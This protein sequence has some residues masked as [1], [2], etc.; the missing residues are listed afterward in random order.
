MSTRVDPLGV[1]S[2]QPERLNY[3][4]GILLDAQDFR[5]EQLYHR[6]RLARALAYLHGYGTVA[7]LRVGWTP[8]LAPN[9]D[10]NL[11]QGRA[12]QLTVGPGLALD[13]LGRL[14]EAPSGLCLLLDN[15]YQNQEPS[16]LA[17]AVVTDFAFRDEDVEEGL[18][19]GDADVTVPSAVIADLFIRFVECEA[20]KTPAFATGPFDALDAVQ[21]ARLRDGF[22]LS[23]LARPGGNPPP[24]LDPWADVDPNA[25]PADRL[26]AL[27]KLAFGLW[28]EDTEDWGPDGPDP[29]SEHAA[30]QN[31]TDLFLARVVIPATS[32][33]AE[34]LPTRVAGAKVYRLSSLRRFVYP[35]G[36]LAHLL[37]I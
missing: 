34:A 27:R 12:E 31:T 15:W 9:A 20:G 29:L 23:L 3:A 17:Q 30:G 33:G 36:L 1:R 10:P 14:I 25:P 19:A 24:P 18:E 32:N 6:G 2:Q 8:P 4:T 35:S 11:P 26:V 16:R 7:G 22:E 37:S 21:A 28:R 13:R 5:A